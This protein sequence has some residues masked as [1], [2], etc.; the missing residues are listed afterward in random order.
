[1]SLKYISYSF[2]NHILMEGFKL[3]QRKIVC[4]MASCVLTFYFRVEAPSLCAHPTLHKFFMLLLDYMFRLI[5][6]HHQVCKL[7][8]SYCTFWTMFG[9][10]PMAYFTRSVVFGVVVCVCK[11]KFCLYNITVTF[12]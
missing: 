11:N 4:S 6:S 3:E 12:A 1:M 8:T 5:P 7:Y 2:K 10:V 9:S